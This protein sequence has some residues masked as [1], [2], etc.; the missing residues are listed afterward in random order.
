M[1]RR[2]VFPDHDA[3]PSPGD[4][5]SSEPCSLTMTLRWAQQ[6]KSTHSEMFPVL[7]YPDT[8]YR[9]NC[10]GVGIVCTTEL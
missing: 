1:S 6:G 7:Y 8:T 4:Q 10:S 5:M 2:A 9:L 3:G